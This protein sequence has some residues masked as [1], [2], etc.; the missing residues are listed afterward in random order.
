MSRIRSAIFDFVKL[1]VV[2]F[3]TFLI[4]RTIA[5]LYIYGRIDLRQVSLLELLFVP[6][7]QVVALW[8]IVRKKPSAS[9]ESSPEEHTR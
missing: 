4:V 3:M 7:G 9:A 2:L 8:V 5:T 6:L 1:W